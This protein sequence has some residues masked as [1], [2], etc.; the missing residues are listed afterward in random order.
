MLINGYKLKEAIKDWEMKRDSKKSEFSSSLKKFP[1]EEKEHPTLLAKEIVEAE[2]AIVK[3]QELQMRYNCLVKVKVLD[4][5]ISLCEAV[6]SHGFAG[7]IEK[8]WKDALIAK[9]DSYDYRSDEKSTTT[10]FSS[11]VMKSSEVML[12]LKRA[13]KFANAINAAIGVAN[14]VEIDFDRVDDKLFA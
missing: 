1:D 13:T 3:L 11:E 10:I 14:G 8:M 7:R 4:N 12:E 5:E 2:S 6:K 9:K